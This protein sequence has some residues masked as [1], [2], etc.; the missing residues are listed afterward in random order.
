MI[1]ETQTNGRVQT[2]MGQSP[3]SA[4]GVADYKL[5]LAEY[6]TLFEECHYDTL[7][8]CAR[9]GML[10]ENW[11]WELASECI[12]RNDLE[13][14]KKL[15][16]V[17]RYDWESPFG[18]QTLLTI[19]ASHATDNDTEIFEYMLQT[20]ADLYECD[21]S[22]DWQQLEFQVKN[23]I[24]NNGEKW[25]GVESIELIKW[26]IERGEGTK[27]LYEKMKEYEK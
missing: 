14:L 20:G 26:A 19:A 6:T 18:Y 21:F 8:S 10:E 27:V 15:H 13:G 24:E 3:G 12:Q 25:Y 7:K 22:E 17:F 16:E 1:A 2:R 23:V 5:K 4:R 9:R 11:L